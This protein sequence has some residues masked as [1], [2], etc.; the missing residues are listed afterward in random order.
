MGDFQ[1]AKRQ[2]G[3][4]DIAR[5]LREGLG[6]EMREEAAADEELTHLQRLRRL[7][8]AEA[9]RAA[10]HRGDRVTARIAGLLL[11]FP[12][13]AVGDDYAT[14][15]DTEGRRFIDIRLDAAEITIEPMPSGGVSSRPL[16][17]TLK[18]R[19]AEHEQDRN[20]IEVYTSG[21]R[22][23]VGTI[24]VAALDHIVIT[25]RT[26]PLTYLPTGLIELVFSPFPPR[27]G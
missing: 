7:S 3:L 6:R 14:L 26:G 5:G 23:I 25:D 15:E 22:S 16:A 10:M 19:L 4:E 1:S 9:V 18:A 8:M 17:A 13:M 11:S 27:T 12:V 21:G 20:Q 24:E 2:D